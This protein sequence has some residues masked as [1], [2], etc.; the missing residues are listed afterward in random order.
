MKEF[1]TEYMNPNAALPQKKPMKIPADKFPGWLMKTDSTNPAIV[2]T[3][4]SQAMESLK[5]AFITST[6]TTLTGIAQT[7]SQM[8]VW[9]TGN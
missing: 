1:L 4:D 5:N 9:I 6:T 3:V 8:F 7:A 2:A